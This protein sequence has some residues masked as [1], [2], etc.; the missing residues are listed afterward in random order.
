MTQ[1]IEIA[2]AKHINEEKEQVARFA[3]EVMKSILLRYKIN[4]K[5]EKP[6]TPEQLMKWAMDYLN[7]F[8]QVYELPILD[9]HF[10]VKTE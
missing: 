4:P 5:L 9:E 3:A 10:M 1:A 6:E 2:I 7:S 8:R